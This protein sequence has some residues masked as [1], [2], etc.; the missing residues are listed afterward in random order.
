[1][2][3][4]LIL[5]FVGI[6]SVTAFGKEEKSAKQAEAPQ[7]AEEAKDSEKK[8]ADMKAKAKAAEE[9]KAK[10]AEEAKAKAAEEAKAKAAE[11]AKAKAAEEAKAKA[12]EEAK[13]K[14]AEEAKAKAAEEAKA[15][16]ADK[17]EIPQQPEVSEEKPA[18]VQESGSA[19][20]SAVQ[21]GVKYECDGGR[22][23]TLHEPGVN[24]ES[25]LCELD[26]AHTEAAA[27]WYAL[28]QSSFCKQKLQELIELYNCVVK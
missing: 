24:D 22:S 4:L 9:A 13:A 5:I 8:P 28:N 19:D 21:T 16:A 2:K 11:E 23:Y 3:T 18:A 26:A 17:K 20:A 6:F 14:A 10:A 12:A 15:K 25:H 7:V 1:M 27:D